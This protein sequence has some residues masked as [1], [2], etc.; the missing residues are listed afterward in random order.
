MP[1][2]EQATAAPG[3]KRQ[4]EPRRAVRVGLKWYKVEEESEDGEV[5][6]LRRVGRP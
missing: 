6:V 5:L 4:V 2:I 3:E 1:E